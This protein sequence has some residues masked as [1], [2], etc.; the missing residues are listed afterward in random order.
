MFGEHITQVVGRLDPVESYE[1]CSN[2]FSNS[3]KRQD[4]MML[5]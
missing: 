4:V 3:L 2:G 5:G 1:F